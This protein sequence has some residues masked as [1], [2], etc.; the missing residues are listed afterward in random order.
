MTYYKGKTV[1]VTGASTGIG[2]ALAK[3]AAQAGAKLILVARSKDKLQALSNELQEQGTE[4]H[5]FVR[6]LSRAKAAEKL[7]AEVD[8]AGLKVDILIN[9]AAY[10]RLG[11][12]GNYDRAD[13]TR[14]VQLDLIALTDLCH[15]YIADM[16]ER[17]GGGIINVASVTA[18]VP[19]PYITV[20]AAIKSY[21]LSLS[22]GLRYEYADAGVRVMALMPA[23][24]E[25]EFAKVAAG[26]SKKLAEKLENFSN[27]GHEQ[28]AQEVAIECLEAFAKD[29][30]FIITGARNRVMFTL[31]KF[32]P[33]TL[34]LSLL[35]KRLQ[36][37][38]AE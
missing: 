23:G 38:L 15:L 19:T 13:Y 29:K 9:N 10:G 12:F 28:T 35:G 31:L 7:Y 1:L 11:N 17:G 30:Q 3:Q 25:S 22:E 24:T 20:Y 18:L 8:E 4:S 21:V 32:L 33:R 36:A 2:Y 37:S 6:D 34:V 26:K 14:M 27:Q 16:V 5:V